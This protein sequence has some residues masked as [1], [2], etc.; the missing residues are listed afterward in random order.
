MP[1]QLPLPVT[2]TA[3][4]AT[5]ARTNL[6]VNAGF[7]TGDFTGWSQ[8]GDPAFTF[9]NAARQA[10]HGGGCAALFGP[11]GTGF[12][13]QSFATVPGAVLD[14]GFWLANLSI[15]RNYF[16]VTLNGA[17]L[18]SLSNA[19]A[20]DYRAYR[21]AATG[22]PSGRNTLTFASRHGISYFA[23]DDVRVTVASVPM[24]APLAPLDAVLLDLAAA[25][26]PRRAEAEAA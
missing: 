5:A 18:F 22:S 19:A 26:R 2:A 16:R 25:R 24:P 3:L 23:L 6:I 10:A 4:A 7:E 17:E 15:A 13:E 9:V 8:A 1:R 21:F 12:L 11:S 14:I 20:F